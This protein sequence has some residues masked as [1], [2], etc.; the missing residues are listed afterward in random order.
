M[1]A[2]ATAVRLLTF[3]FLKALVNRRWSGS[4]HD[5]WGRLW[6]NEM[7]KLSSFRCALL[8]SAITVICPAFAIADDWVAERLRGTVLIYQ[9]GEWL[10]LER[11]DV[12]SDQ[13]HIKT[14]GNGGVEFVRGAERINVAAHTMIQILDRDGDRF[15]NVHQHYGEI[16]VEAER[17]D[18][19]HFGILTPYLA[20]V[21]KGTEFVVKSG[22]RGASVSVDR[23][24]VS[25]SQPGTGLNADI[26]PGQFAGVGSNGHFAV[27]SVPGAELPIVRDAG[28]TAIAGAAQVSADAT[29]AGEATAE[30]APGNRNGNAGMSGNGNAGARGG[31]DGK[32]NATGNGN[33]NAG[34]NSSG[35]AE[36]NERGNAGGSGGVGGEGNGNAG[37][38]GNG[39]GQRR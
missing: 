11:G 20:T 7:M 14:L 33:G 12:V 1:P 4:R 22:S 6:P 26:I 19:N 36:R 30:S 32:G 28:G 23:G 10:P 34:G 5:I 37:G 17:R 8:A 21:V 24:Q 3:R 31:A 18:V 15:T 27:S 29:T 39:N 25:V 2:N 16:A 13:S 9:Q 35:N 38:N